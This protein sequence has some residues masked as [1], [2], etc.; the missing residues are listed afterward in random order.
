M[1][2]LSTNPNLVPQPT[3]HPPVQGQW[4]AQQVNIFGRSFGTPIGTTKHTL[5]APPPPMPVPSP[6][7][8]VPGANTKRAVDYYADYGGCGW[9]R[10]I[11]PALLMNLEQ[12]ATINGVT[13][14]EVSPSFY[15]GMQAV[16]LQRQATPVQLNF[17]KFLSEVRT[18]TNM[19]LIYEV[20]DIIFKDDIPLYNRCREGFEDPSILACSLEMMRMSDEM[21]VTCQYMKDYYQAKT[22][23]KNITVVPNYPA[24]MWMER[25]YN[26]TAI[27]KNYNENR[28]QPRVAYVGSGTHFDVQNKTN[29]HDDFYHVHQEIIK[30]RRKFKWVF[31]GGY[32][33]LLKPYIDSGEMEFF[34]WFPLKDLGRAYTDTKCQ[35]VY[36]PLTDCTFNK[37]KSNIKYLESACCGIPGVF[38]DLVTYEDAPLRFKT[39]TDLVNQ[40]EVLLDSS[41]YMKYSKMA[42]AYADTMWLDDHL[43]EFT[44][45]YF[46]RPGQPERKALL[47]RN[48]DQKNSNPSSK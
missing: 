19:K 2:V 22:G 13:T 43:S 42:K 9:W 36:A 7:L 38:Q 28:N 16:R 17:M 15:A 6:P 11:A 31:V 21:S 20:D 35:A 32:P 26:P 14:M 47:Q 27:V 12:K 40:L 37:A 24:K 18:Q 48:P 1:K 23:V 46:T 8:E 39:G 33:L 5:A 41:N 29:Q 44:E 25:Y 45:L 3:Q 4:S 30:S 34:P 10:L